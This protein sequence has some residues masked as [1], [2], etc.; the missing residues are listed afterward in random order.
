VAQV[1]AEVVDLALRYLESA[2]RGL[3]HVGFRVRAPLHLRLSECSLR[4]ERLLR[5][6]YSM[7][8][9]VAR[10][11]HR[12]LGF[13]GRGLALAQLALP[14]YWSHSERVHQRTLHV[15]LRGLPGASVHG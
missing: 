1:R 12:T 8:Y 9:S 2:D 6:I 10:S 11:S 14:R 4:A 5:D 3:S 13:A 7:G 15:A